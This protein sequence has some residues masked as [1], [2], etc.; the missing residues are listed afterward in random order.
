VSSSNVGSL[1]FD[2]NA[3]IKDAVTRGYLNNSQ[4]LSVVFAGF[5]IWT[6]GTGVSSSRFCAI[7]N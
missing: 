4:Y 7:V 1:A 6:G 5:E 3:F 2:L